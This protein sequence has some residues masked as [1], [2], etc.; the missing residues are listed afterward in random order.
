MGRLCSA[1]LG[2]AVLPGLTAT[3]AVLYFR[4]YVVPD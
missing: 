1:I 2:I 3:P 4:V